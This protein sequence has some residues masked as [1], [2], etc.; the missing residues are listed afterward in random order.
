MWALVVILL[1]NKGVG[2]QPIGAYDTMEECFNSRELI[3]ANSPK[4][5]INY[6]LVCVRTN[7][8]EKI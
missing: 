3:M 7:L 5:K 2:F 4:P 6:E 1:S 8:L